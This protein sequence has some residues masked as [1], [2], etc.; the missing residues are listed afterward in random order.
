[1][2]KSILLIGSNGQVG[3]E[4]QHILQPYGN[5]ITVAR[6][7]I[8]LTQPDTIREVIRENQPQIIINA[9]AYTAVDKAESEPELASAINAIAPGIMGEEAAKLGSFLIHIST[10]YVFDGNHS[11][12]YQE[13]DATNPI[14]VYGRTKLAGEQAVQNTSSQY[15]ILRTAWVYG[16][17]GKSNFVKTMLRLGTQRP[18]LRVVAD[19]IGSPTW[20]KDIAK[21][22]AQIIPKL[23]SEIV[24]IY[25]YT[26]SG[27]ASW[28]DFAVT[29]VEEAQ[30]LGYNLNVQR[31]VP[32]S[33]AEYPTPA[34]RP[35][36][37][38][39]STAK[40]AKVLETHPPHW[41]LSLKQMLT[42]L[43]TG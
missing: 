27:V 7:T 3:Q 15:L 19:Q 14:N 40:I 31:T 2:N 29:L 34:H 6:P 5:I 36:Y 4:L 42:E 25:N 20:A 22:I 23:S 12:P 1:M 21:A 38:V 16:T 30:Q 8:D 39:L 35:S 18:E 24:G 37:S 10:D 13:T 9:A 17:F 28:Y 32:I 11:R 43:K 41:R 33:T 26:N